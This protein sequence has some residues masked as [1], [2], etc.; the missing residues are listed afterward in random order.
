M[1]YFV[2]YHDAND[3]VYSNIFC[4]FKLLFPNGTDAGRKFAQWQHK[5]M[6]EIEH[7]T[8]WVK[9]EQSNKIRISYQEEG[10]TWFRHPVVYSCNALIY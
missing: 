5:Q 7:D 2:F 3:T 8:E 4:F 1:F 10:A 6:E 9:S